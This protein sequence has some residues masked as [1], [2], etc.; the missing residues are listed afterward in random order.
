VR[1]RLNPGV[2]PVERV[3]G[4]LVIDEGRTRGWA[5]AEKSR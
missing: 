2:V 3:P 1:R 5:F 4:S